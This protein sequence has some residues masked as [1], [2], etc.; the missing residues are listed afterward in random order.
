MAPAGVERCGIPLSY[1]PS[2]FFMV[3]GASMPFWFGFVS[4]TVFPGDAPMLA[5]A[6]CSGA[7]SYCIFPAL[8]SPLLLCSGRPSGVAVDCGTR[9][10]GSGQWRPAR[11]TSD[12]AAHVHGRG[13][14]NRGESEVQPPVRRIL[15]RTRA[16]SRPPSI[17]PSRPL[18]EKVDACG[19]VRCWVPS[20]LC[21]YVSQT[22][23]SVRD[24]T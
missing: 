16:Y 24:S 2:A 20:C 4:A 10:R 13:R 5:R 18:F 22:T 3:F 7:D 1:I 11:G 9:D 14:R 15:P 19:R 12:H 17:S 8:V 21:A 6:P 23:T